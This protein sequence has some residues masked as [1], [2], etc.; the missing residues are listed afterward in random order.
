MLNKNTYYINIAIAYTIMSIIV[1]INKKMCNYLFRTLFLIRNY[2]L[3]I[4]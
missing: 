4:L 1:L 3:I 2:W